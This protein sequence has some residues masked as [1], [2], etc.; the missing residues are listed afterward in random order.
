[1][2]SAA[3]KGSGAGREKGRGGGGRGK[4]RNH[5]ATTKCNACE[6]ELDSTHFTNNQWSMGPGKARCKICVEQAQAER[7]NKKSAQEEAP[8]TTADED[9]KPTIKCTACEK[10]LDSTHYTKNQLSMGPGKSRCKICVEQAQAERKK[11]QEEA[12]AKAD[13]KK[14]NDDKTP[15]TSNMD[16]PQ[17]QDSID[18]AGI[19]KWLQD[20]LTNLGHLD[21]SSVRNA[22]QLEN[23]CITADDQMV[24]LTMWLEDRLIR[25]W[26]MDDERQ[27]LR[28]DYWNHIDKYLEALEC[29]KSYF[30]ADWRYSLSHR[31]RVVY[32]LVSC[33]TSEAFGDVTIPT[34][35]AA[36]EQSASLS[37]SEPSQA[38]VNSSPLNGGGGQS[39]VS[40]SSTSEL[41]SKFQLGFSVGDAEVDGILLS[42]RMRLLMQLERDQKDINSAI[43]QIQRIT[44]GRA[45]PLKE[46]K[47][48]SHNVDKPPPSNRKSNSNSNRN[49]KRQ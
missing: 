8:T 24:R 31:M 21:P 28:N 47:L 44:A 33:A 20:A 19:Q 22:M 46:A 27:Q 38:K 29:P 39:T 3:P 10:E 40:S 45:K 49:R 12:R 1:M 11:M 5:T 2:S 36:V 48:R 17:V 43:A 42:I 9:K 18:G 23:E 6:K 4:G 26:S 32:W 15:T 41:S 16:A 34:Q 13:D 37:K 25:L 14:P 35:D 30:S 7:N